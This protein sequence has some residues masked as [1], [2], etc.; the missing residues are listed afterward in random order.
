[1]K[2][3]TRGQS[4]RLARVSEPVQVYL[5]DVD[6][7]RLDR[8][9][10]KLDATKSDVLRRG[11]AA[12]EAQAAASRPKAVTRIPLPISREKPGVKRG[13][14]LSDHKRLRDLMDDPN[15]LL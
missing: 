5:S 12:L 13:V 11:L 4:R 6:L 1:M 10:Q 8:L 3:P 9:T 15:A 7:A 14:D 2:K